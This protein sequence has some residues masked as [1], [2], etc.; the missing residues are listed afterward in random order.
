[1]LRVVLA[2]SDL[3]SGGILRLVQTLVASSPT[4]LLLLLLLGVVDSFL[5][6]CLSF[7]NGATRLRVAIGLRFVSRRDAIF[8]R[9]KR[10][11]PNSFFTTHD[12]VSYR[13][14]SRK[15]ATWDFL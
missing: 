10:F 3:L 12:L 2:D 4:R 11:E 13:E 14:I 6:L 8:K 1:M 15:L 7:P 5:G 9:P